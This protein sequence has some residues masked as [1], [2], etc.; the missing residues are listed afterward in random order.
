MRLSSFILFNVCLVIVLNLLGFQSMSSSFIAAMGG[1][2]SATD[3]IT[4]LFQDFLSAKSAGALLGGAFTTLLTF[5]ALALLGFS[6]M[7]AIPL[8]LGILLFMYF[9]FPYGL[10]FEM[11]FAPWNWIFFLIFNT[12]LILGLVDFTRGGGA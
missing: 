6:S 4:S 8:A 12:L 1:G 11:A 7:Y 9:L 5:S 3:L 2:A 10:L